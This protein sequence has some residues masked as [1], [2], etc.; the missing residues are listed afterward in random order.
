MDRKNNHRPVLLIPERKLLYP[1]K[2]LFYPMSYSFKILLF[3]VFLNLIPVSGLLAQSWS[4]M[5]EKD[6]IKVYTRRESNSSMKSFKGDVTFKASLQKV[7][8]MLG[9]DKNNDW[10]DKAITDVK[11]LGFKE[12]KY[13]Q[14]YLIY[15][16]PWPFKKRDIVTE[17]T[18]TTN[19]V[20]GVRIY[21]A[22]PLPNKV[23]EKSN[24]VRIK[25]FNQ[26]WTVEP[27]EKG[28]IHVTLEGS[29]NPG[30]S[31]PAWLYN[32]VIT[33]APLKMLFSLREKSTS[34]K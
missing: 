15:N 8:S 25:E 22:I 23:P 13:I 24:L 12:N 14:Y 34:G 19:T 9:N 20:S 27:Q 10:W 26:T 5:K 7:Y 2:Y 3:L 32:M 30:G 16:L 21:T 28:T 11:V 33:E 18:I 4:F 31:I 6:G 1:F 17:T 29:V